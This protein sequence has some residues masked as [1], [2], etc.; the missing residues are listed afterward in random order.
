[1]RNIYNNGTSRSQNQTCSVLCSSTVIHIYLFVHVSF[2]ND[3]TKEDSRWV[4]GLS[5]PCTYFRKMFCCICISRYLFLKFYSLS[6]LLKGSNSNIRIYRPMKLWI[7][8]TT[9][10]SWVKV[11]YQNFSLSYLS[12]KS[13]GMLFQWTPYNDLSPL[14]RN[15]SSG[16]ICT[17]SYVEKKKKKRHFL[18]RSYSSLAL[19]SI[20]R[21]SMGLFSLQPLVLLGLLSW[22]TCCDLWASCSTTL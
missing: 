4:L 1:M 6:T 2:D 9:L 7:R 10:Q 20:S 16:F 22:E 12:Q 17:Q 15:T 8:C 19:L 18:T 11:Y 13:Q 14:F 3:L 21:M 5:S